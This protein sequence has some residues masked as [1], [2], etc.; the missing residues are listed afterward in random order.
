MNRLPEAGC[1]KRVV[2]GGLGIVSPLGIGIE[3]FWKRL[4]GG[5]C[6]LGESPPSAH[7]IPVPSRA[8]TLA[9]LAQELET[10]T[11]DRSLRRVSNLSRYAVAAARLALDRAGE[12][13]SSQSRTGAG[14]RAG[15]FRAH[16]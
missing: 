14:G 8:A 15:T 12:C 6:A 10:V 9:E 16:P 4:A 11:D 5:D 1:R 3:P 13:S 7:S 2:V